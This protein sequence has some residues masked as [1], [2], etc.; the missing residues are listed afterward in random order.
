MHRKS[1]NFKNRH[2]R[3]FPISPFP[4]FPKSFPDSADGGDGG[5]GE[6]VD[7]AECQC[8]N[9]G[10][11][12]AR[13]SNVEA[14][15]PPVQS[16]ECQ[17][18]HCRMQSS[19][20]FIA[21]CRMSASSFQGAECRSLQCKVQSARVSSAERRVRKSPVQSARV[22]SAECQNLQNKMLTECQSLWKFKK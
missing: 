3:F 10:R 2:F 13:V 16:A 5:D 8:R 7:R 21:E 1:G 18:L 22:S 9:R 4:H 19:N 20:V 11:Q 12:N 15:E 17:R 14:P 6:M